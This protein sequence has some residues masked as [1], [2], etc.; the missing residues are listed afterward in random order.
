MD[1]SRVQRGAMIAGVAG[2]VLF[3]VMFLNWFGIDQSGAQDLSLEE[4]QDLSGFV[5]AGATSL[6][7]NAWQAFSFIDIILL[8]TIIAAVGLAA[9]QAFAT[10]INLP[11]ALS[12]V[13]TALGALSTLLV[14]Y[15]ILDT[16]Y[17]LDRDYGVF[18]GLV[19]AAALTYGGFIAMQ[20]EGTSL[21]READRLRDRDAGG[22]PAG[23]PPP[24][25]SPPPAGGPPPPAA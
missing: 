23:S 24:P 4:A 2:I 12:A 19:V 22:P 8:V 7:I 15:R 11:V 5:S 18:V 6:D 10:R 16:P 9:I 1:V 13:V 17:S 20:E 14:L 3:I 21:G 25:G